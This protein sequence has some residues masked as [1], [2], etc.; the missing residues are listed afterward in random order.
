MVS[1]ILIW[2][3]NKGSRIIIHAYQ[4]RGHVI[5]THEQASS[6]VDEQ[7]KELILA[8]WMGR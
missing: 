8:N 6:D 4:V 3:L 5:D 7:P 2:L 1:S